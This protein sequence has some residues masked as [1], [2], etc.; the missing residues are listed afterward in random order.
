ME[1]ETPLHET[2]ASNANPLSSD[3]P[4]ELEVFET[5][6]VEHRK[7]GK[8]PSMRVTYHNSRGR[9]VSEWWCFEHGGFAGDQARRSWL[10]HCR[11]EFVH[12]RI[13]ESTNEALTR[14]RELMSP[15]RVWIKQEGQFERVLSKVFP[16]IDELP[17]IRESSQVRTLTQ[18]LVDDD[19]PF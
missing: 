6:Y 8:P 13:P 15:A 12:S 9:S 1:R 14:V 5:T 18:N 2:E 19:I 3:E 17:P 4:E 10:K 11:P 16:A 7:E